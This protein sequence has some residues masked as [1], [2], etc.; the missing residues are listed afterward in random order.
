MSSRKQL[1][2]V[3][4]GR[5][6]LAGWLDR[7]PHGPES[8]HVALETLLRPA[9]SELGWGDEELR[10]ILSLEHVIGMLTGLVYERTVRRPWPG[11][12]GRTPMEDFLAARGRR[13]RPGGRAYFRALQ[14]ASCELLEV[15]TVQ[16][17]RSIDVR[18][19]GTMA[20]ART[21]HEMAGSGQ[22]APGDH[23]LGEVLPMPAGAIFA[24]GLRRIDQDRVAALVGLRGEPLLSGG[25]TAWAIPTF[26]A[27][28]ARLGLPV[29]ERSARSVPLADVEARETSDRAVEDTGRPIAD[30]SERVEERAS[31]EET[32]PE[33]RGRLLERIRKLYAMA[34]Q[35]EASPHEAEIALRRCQSL[36]TRFGITEADLETHDF[37]VESAWRAK[38]V[39]MHVQDLAM[40]VA[41]LHDVLFVLGYDA[42][43]EFRGYEIDVRVARLTLDYLVDAV[44]RALG[45]RRRAGDFPPGRTASYDYRQ[46][47]AA[48][49]CKRVEGIVEEREHAER[50]A[51]PAGTA[52]TVRKREIVQRECGQDLVKSYARTRGSL[53][54]D[55]VAA[56][57]EDGARVSLD[58]QVGHA[59]GALKLPKS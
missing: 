56:G 46:A 23:L 34:Q 9:L 40:G 57:R 39:P 27:A 2:E 44:E 12:A 4:H 58:G 53:H 36:M 33:S 54:A 32:D 26:T 45:A 35:T 5:R 30:G 59:G 16:P 51:S 55:A 7:Q 13:L 41:Q 17:G 19:A 29:I 11:G 18:R 31:V 28:G 14:D 24:A 21:V 42:C 52:L 6:A 49:V 25:M 50:S 48:E 15:V 8:F 20:A 1:A 3:D 10:A 37:T 38:R 22:L 43:P 47:F